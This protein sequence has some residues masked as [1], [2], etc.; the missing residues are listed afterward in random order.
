MLN[1]YDEILNLKSRVAELEK[2]VEN[3]RRDAL[4][5]AAEICNSIGMHIMRTQ[6]NTQEAVEKL[7]LTSRC[8]K[9]ILDPNAEKELR[10]M[11]QAYSASNNERRTE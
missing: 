5:D 1:I 2:A 10:E 3:S 9:A 4:R 8:S 7:I 11:E 6:G